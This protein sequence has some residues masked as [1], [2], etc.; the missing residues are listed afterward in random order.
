MLRDDGTLQVNSAGAAIE[1]YDN[2]DI[3]NF[4]RVWTGFTRQG[5]RSNLMRGKAN[6][7]NFVD[8]NTVV[9]TDRDR[10]P[11][12]NLY[13]HHIGDGY[14]LCSDIPNRA[15]LRSGA[16]YRRV[17]G[18]EATRSSWLAMHNAPSIVLG[19]SSSLASALCGQSGGVPWYGDGVSAN[20]VC[21]LA[22]EVSLPADLACD[23]DECLVFNDAYVVQL[24]VGS[25]ASN[26]SIWYEY[27][28]PAC[29]ELTFHTPMMR[30]ESPSNEWTCADD[31]AEMRTA[32]L[33]S[34]W[35]IWNAQCLMGVQV[36]HRCML[37]HA[38][39]YRYSPAF[40]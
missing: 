27:I 16:R 40:S 23:G 14:P 36:G 26:L 17:F 11:K 12:V 35:S 2:N 9:P 10:F 7:V 24:T 38:V 29:V 13:D 8:P 31:T 30:V 28:R 4:A 20:G 15:F 37:L 19:S 22:D 6:Y 18:F 39:T 1:T 5:V 33:G 3:L 34:G 32:L 21:A 25:P